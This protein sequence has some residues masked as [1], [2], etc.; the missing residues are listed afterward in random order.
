MTSIQKSF[1]LGCSSARCGNGSSCNHHYQASGCP[2][3]FS[4]PWVMCMDGTGTYHCKPHS[5]I[6]LAKK[7][8]EVFKKSHELSNKA[9]THICSYGDKP[10]YKISGAQKRIQVGNA[11]PGAV[12][13]CSNIQDE[14]KTG[15]VHTWCK[16]AGASEAEAASASETSLASETS[17]EEANPVNTEEVVVEKTNV[18][19]SL[20][21]GIDDTI[22]FSFI[23]IVALLLMFSFFN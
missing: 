15:E 16:N 19:S 12:I 2:S 20:I 11:P 18:E 13:Y 14:N 5:T 3:I 1:F 7:D 23:I 8:I 10:A 22:T 17:S 9:C 21:E 6:S 4:R